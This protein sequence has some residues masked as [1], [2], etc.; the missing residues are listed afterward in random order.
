MK[1]LLRAPFV[2][3]L[4]CLFFNGCAS[5]IRP[6]SY[7]A[8]IVGKWGHK[9]RIITFHADGSWGV[10]RHETAREDISGRRWRVE[11]DKFF[12]TFP[13][14]NGGGTPVHMVTDVYRITSF[15]SQSFT[16]RRDDGDTQVYDREP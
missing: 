1:R 7:S 16:I 14:D 3:I 5:H 4:L 15:T 6:E 8:S 13:S 12:L 10:Q 2:L 9:N 11:G